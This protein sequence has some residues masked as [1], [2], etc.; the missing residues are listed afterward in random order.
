MHPATDFLGFLSE[1]S[2]CLSEAW[3]CSVPSDRP[4]LL[5]AADGGLL[6]LD[7]IGELG[8]DEQAMLLRALEERRFL[9]VGADE[10]SSSDFRL[11]AGTNRDL[12]LRVAQGLFRDDLLAR[13]DLWTFELPPL[14]ERAEDIEPNVE[15]ELERFASRTNRLV[16]F[17]AEARAAY[18]AFA[19]SPGATWPG[20]FRDLAASV[21]RMATLAPGG[22]IGPEVV[23]AEIARL[24]R[25]WALPVM[26]GAAPPSAPYSATIAP[27]DT[28]GRTAAA[29]SAAH[30]GRDGHAAREEQGGRDDAQG[31]LGP[32]L[33]PEGLNTLDRFDRAQLAEVVRVCRQSRSLSE[34]GRTLFAASRSRRASVNDADRLRKYLARFGLSWFAVRG[35]PGVSPGSA[36]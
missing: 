3:L 19:T 20:N 23:D 1:S 35:A 5:R 10:E 6:F 27:T 29:N 17:S 8:L 16:R 22:R 7:E 34:A 32:L 31:L 18:L 9:P 2:Q 14:R 36:P 21:T 26:T 13:I 12:R 28:P 15:F 24:R 30:D 33:G 4:G 11:I 25:A